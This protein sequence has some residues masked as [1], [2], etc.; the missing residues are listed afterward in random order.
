[1]TDLDLWFSSGIGNMNWDL[2][3][4]FWVGI[5]NCGLRV[6]LEIGVGE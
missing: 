1:M 4:R 2:G 5:V 3:L 6:R